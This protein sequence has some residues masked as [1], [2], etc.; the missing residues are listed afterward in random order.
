MDQGPK[1][2]PE[3]NQLQLNPSDQVA[4]VKGNLFFKAKKVDIAGIIAANKLDIS[5]K[6]VAIQGNVNAQLAKIVSDYITLA[7]TGKM[8][9][10]DRCTL[11]AH[12]EAIL[13]GKIVGGAKA[14]TLDSTG[15][16]V[17][18]EKIH[19][20]YLEIITKNLLSSAHIDVQGEVKFDAKDGHII[21]EKNGK[22]KAL[23][24][25][26]NAQEAR[27]DAPIEVID[28]FYD[29]YNGIKFGK[30]D[31]FIVKNYLKIN[32]PNGKVE[33]DAKIMSRV[34][35]ICA[36]EF[37]LMRSGILSADEHALIESKVHTVIDG[38]LESRKGSIE[39]SGKEA[40][41]NI[42]GSIIADENLRVLAKN[43]RTWRNENAR[44]QIEAE[45]IYFEANDGTIELSETDL[46]A[47]KVLNIKGKRF[48]QIVESHI[49]GKE[50][51][52]DLE[53]DVYV[54]RLTSMKAE[55]I[56]IKSHIFTNLQRSLMKGNAIVIDS[57]QQY[58][59]GFMMADSMI[60]SS[61]I[62]TMGPI[63]TLLGNNI[64]VSSHGVVMGG[65]A[66][67]TGTN[68]TV[69]STG[70][71]ALGL[72]ASIIGA[73]NTNITT[74]SLLM[75]PGTFIGGARVNV[76]APVVLM[77]PG[78]MMFGGISLRGEGLYA[79]GADRTAVAAGTDQFGLDFHD[80]N[81]ANAGSY[82]HETTTNVART[83]NA[84]SVGSLFGTAKSWFKGKES[85]DEIAQ[86]KLEGKKNSLDENPQEEAKLDQKNKKVSQQTSPQGAHIKAHGTAKIRGKA[87]GGNLTVSGNVVK[88]FMNSKIEGEKHVHLGIGALAEVNGQIEG[89]NVTAEG[90]TFKETEAK[91]ENNNKSLKREAHANLLLGKEA[92]IKAKK[93]AQLLNLA[94]VRI[95]D[96]TGTR[97]SPAL[98]AGLAYVD[99]ENLETGSG[100]WMETGSAGGLVKAK[101]FKL[102]GQIGLDESSEKES[103]K[104]VVKKTPTVR[105]EQKEGGEHFSY[106]TN[107]DERMNTE[108][109]AES[110]LIFD[111]DNSG[112]H[113]GGGSSLRVEANKGVHV[114]EG[115]VASSES[116]QIYGTGTVQV[117][118]QLGKMGAR[119]SI[120]GMEFDE[121][122]ELQKH[123]LQATEAEE[124]GKEFPKKPDIAP[125][126]K[127][128]QGRSGHLAGQLTATNLKE[129]DLKGSMTVDQSSLVSAQKMNA[130]PSFRLNVDT[131]GGENR[132][133]FEGKEETSVHGQGTTSGSN[134]AN[135]VVTHRG[136]KDQA[137][138]FGYSHSEDNATTV[139]VNAQ[140]STIKF[141]QTSKEGV[142]GGQ[143]FRTNAHHLE[144]NRATQHAAETVHYDLVEDT[145]LD[146]EISTKK[147]TV[148]TQG[149]LTNRTGDPLKI[150]LRNGGQKA[151]FHGR[152]VHFAGVDIENAN[153]SKIEVGDEKSGTTHASLKDV[154]VYGDEQTGVLVTGSES[155]AVDRS[156]IQGNVDV[157]SEKGKASLT[158][159]NLL[160]DAQVYGEEETEVRTNGVKGDLRAGYMV[161]GEDGQIRK[162]KKT[163]FQQNVSLAKT[164]DQHVSVAGEEIDHGNN[165]FRRAS[166]VNIVGTSS[167]D[168]GGNDY[169][170][171]SKEQ[172]GEHK[173][174]T[175]GN[176][177][178]NAE[179]KGLKTDK[180]G[181]LTRQGLSEEDIKHNE[182]LSRIHR[183][184]HEGF[185]AREKSIEYSKARGF[186]AFAEGGDGEVMVE[187]GIDP[188]LDKIV[189]RGQ[190]FV[191]PS[192]LTVEV[193][194][195]V[196]YARENHI[197]GRLLQDLTAKFIAENGSFSDQTIFYKDSQVG[198]SGA[199]TEVQSKDVKIGGNVHGESLNARGNNITYEES[200]KR[201]LEKETNK[202]EQTINMSGSRTAKTVRDEAQEINY[203]E[204]HLTTIREGGHMEVNASQ[205]HQS[206]GAHFH[207]GNQARLAI[208]RDFRNEVIED[209][210]KQ[211]EIRVFDPS[212]KIILDGRITGGSGTKVFLKSEYLE[213]HGLIEVEQ[214]VIDV[215][216][217]VHEGIF[218]GADFTL[219]TDI[220]QGSGTFD[221]ANSLDIT[222]K[223]EWKSKHIRLKGLDL[224]I[225]VPYGEHGKPFQPQEFD[226]D[227]LEAGNS[228]FVS[229][230]L[231][232][233]HIKGLMS[234]KLEGEGHGEIHGA[235]LALQTTDPLVILDRNID[236]KFKELGLKCS[237]FFMEKGSQLRTNAFSLNAGN[238]I[239][240]SGSVIDSGD[241]PENNINIDVCNFYQAYDWNPETNKFLDYE[242][243]DESEPEYWSPA[244]INAGGDLNIHA[245]IPEAERSK[246]ENRGRRGGIDSRGGQFTSRH[247]SIIMKSDG[248]IVIIPITYLNLKVKSKYVD[249]SCGLK[250]KHYKIKEELIGK[251][252]RFSAAKRVEIAAGEGSESILQ[253]VD[254]VAPEIVLNNVEQ[255]E[256]ELFFEKEKI[257]SSLSPEGVCITTAVKIGVSVAATAYLGPYAGAAVSG[258][259]NTAAEMGIERTNEGL[260]NEDEWGIARQNGKNAAISMALAFGSEKFKEFQKAYTASNETVDAAGKSVEAAESIKVL[261]EL[262]NEVGKNIVRSMAREGLQVLLNN[263]KN[264]PDWEALRSGGKRQAL[265]SMFKAGLNYFSEDAF[266]EFDIKK[267]DPL[268]EALINL[269]SQLFADA[270]KQALE[271]N[272]KVDE[273]ALL[274]T[275]E[276][277]VIGE[278]AEFAGKKAASKVEAEFGSFE[279]IIDKFNND[280][281]STDSTDLP[282]PQLDTPNHPGLSTIPE[283]DYEDD[284]P[285]PKGDTSIEQQ[286][287]D[288]ASGADQSLNTREHGDETGSLDPASSEIPISDGQ[289]N[290][291]KGS[292]TQNE[293][294]NTNRSPEA[295]Q[296]DGQGTDSNN[297]PNDFVP[298]LIP[299]NDLGPDYSK[300]S[301]NGGQN[302]TQS[303][304][305]CFIQGTLIWTKDGLKK[306]ED[307]KPGDLVKSCA[308]DRCVLSKVKSLPK[309]KDPVESILY[310]KINGEW[311]GSTPDHPFFIKD[312]A[313]GQS[314]VVEAQDLTTDDELYFADPNSGRIYLGTLE[315]REGPFAVDELVFDLSIQGTK[316]RMYADMLA[317][318]YQAEKDEY[319]RVPS[320]ML[321]PDDR[322][323]VKDLNEK[324]YLAGVD[325][326][327]PVPAGNL[328]AKEKVVNVYNLEVEKNHNYF[329]G[330]AHCLVHN[331]NFGD[332]EG[333]N[334]D[335][336]PLLGLAGKI[337][338]EVE[339]QAG[340]IAAK[341]VAAAEG[342]A[343]AG[344]GAGLGPLAVAIGSVAVGVVGFADPVGDA[345]LR[346]ADGNIKEE[347]RD[348]FPQ[349]PDVSQEGDDS[350]P[351][352]LRRQKQGNDHDP[353]QKKVALPFSRDDENKPFIFRPEDREKPENRE[354]KI[355]N[356]P[357][358]GAVAE[359]PV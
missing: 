280:S 91:D 237:T 28:A 286:R 2:R 226:F 57:D 310:L 231:D 248:N 36:E 92:Q 148:K 73:W 351:E 159:S 17:V 346:D 268:P 154:N 13:R 287:N 245:H 219:S 277:G 87:F 264:K 225:V 25:S 27:L 56:N 38:L 335:G 33:I 10:S 80:L 229:G 311:I 181:N 81:V 69:R 327:D 176:T 199:Q 305:H 203:A 168:Q 186:S 275:L 270:S 262:A 54:G 182:E 297:V 141:E 313:S 317:V 142:G 26:V 306:I 344:A 32:S 347:F 293:N 232:S 173:S 309:R 246:E 112:Q 312:G 194:E 66:T 294:N 68:V 278:L 319:E 355:P 301:E 172:I 72:G 39:I 352:Y 163:S 108:L 116:N 121:E 98:V 272:G 20:A 239:Q 85:E 190:S 334:P 143:H 46:I 184:V 60:L 8:K 59:M 63:G 21:L 31:H 193:G 155:A 160:G 342:A 318:R 235:K 320:W 126:G 289:A 147:P 210:E 259:F 316:V 105:F 132:V 150:D 158:R 146:G 51:K 124:Q 192:D 241:N 34:V 101:N 65:G 37:F 204:G 218:N 257:G 209:S 350:I 267:D 78:S 149:E 322:I 53:E 48:W 223:K 165:R 49:S 136:K 328:I 67:I 357:S 337:L 338:P 207:L 315:D 216:E 166:E 258:L 119:T 307:I 157:K 183:M 167:D 323:V 131:S 156:R 71:V 274:D 201:T 82:N 135:V 282:E 14:V 180:S 70:T 43:I 41:L 324:V 109:K 129:A 250:K 284:S 95:K 249:G 339:K 153:G 195:F 252:A 214:T 128:V 90:T 175:K 304:P 42:S 244:A 336:L 12:I 179:Y 220:L 332:T 300:L 107:V 35:D 79:Y 52:L 187:Q 110:E 321:N 253:S 100:R 88:T 76:L 354:I 356:W 58:V 273:Q 276:S 23:K 55:Q 113:V 103:S 133:D 30:M 230:A 170:S 40:D 263:D 1:T 247:G 302:S 288:K 330:T 74:S 348:R 254:I 260:R 86:K 188:G 279:I 19:D 345:N 29:V 97:A 205:V 11:E 269:G 240:A 114:R 291:A 130:D 118:G 104:Q 50:I 256:R 217:L 138:S 134:K 227:L 45:D 62:F 102:R 222:V 24:L 233:E 285:S 99:V 206:K 125:K 89:E 22:I 283:G 5:A 191:I 234:G 325:T 94:Q 3:K 61:K 212:E 333:E 308:G 178:N 200:A 44:P 343:A 329:V 115:T 140:N 123:V 93:N 77:A 96:R 75:G 15:G 358:S 202:A 340:R 152:E 208:G 177:K 281:S 137:S 213:T 303:D 47:E 243:Q 236:V 299:D 18:N 151:E 185:S 83:I 145:A 6:Q 111:S 298:S 16:V 189:I 251:R 139:E 64:Q 359:K 266:T 9:F 144:T 265:E 261:N 164:D 314:I 221:I 117:D 295:Q 169:G 224:K 331:C 242:R 290:I 353:E 7:T 271:N 127:L 4:T 215:E 292:E 326:I 296:K 171:N 162:S 106:G 197:K 341:G 122:R 238:L 349:S 198:T 84:F 161:S 196:S 228:I 174:E 120:L 211:E 255:S